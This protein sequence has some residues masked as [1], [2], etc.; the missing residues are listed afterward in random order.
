MILYIKK[1]VEGVRIANNFA[2]RIAVFGDLGVVNGQSIPRL[3]KYVHDGEFDAVI[4]NGDFAY[5][6]DDE[7]GYRGDEFMRQIE[8]F[9]AYVPYQT[10]GCQ[11]RV[12]SFVKDLPEWSAVRISDYG[13][14]RLHVLNASHVHIQQISDD[15]MD[16]NRYRNDLK[17]QME[18]EMSRFEQEINRATY[19]QPTSQIQAK[20]LPA[21]F[22]PPQIQRQQQNRAQTSSS[23]FIIQSN[24]LSNAVLPM[25]GNY[26]NRL[27][28]GKNQSLPILQQNRFPVMLPTQS[29]T[30]LNSN[31]NSSIQPSGLQPTPSYT[32]TP[33]GL[34]TNVHN[35]P[36][37]TP[38]T[39]STGT[40][41]SKSNDSK[42]KKQKKALRVAGGQTWEDPSLQ[43]WGQDDFRI[44]CG[45][46]G[47]QCYKFIDIK[48]TIFV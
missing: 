15:Q 43:E 13:F 10:S 27:P 33:M 42:N 45:D 28:V 4:H 31:L 5:N 17:K 8:P 40:K 21:M 46:L 9:A 12:D 6:L 44:F 30:S 38:A 20:P 29:F 26:V 39:T 3:Q 25:H 14:A 48:V 36:N 47:F 34:P 23:S 32:V 19:P 7:N 37:Y 18:D 35:V 41:K 11:E 1:K 22:I 24:Q 16:Y 2:P